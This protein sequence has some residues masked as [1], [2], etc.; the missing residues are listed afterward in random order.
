MEIPF[1]VWL[2]RTSIA[3]AVLAIII[4]LWPAIFF[5]AIVLAIMGTMCAIPLSVVGLFL[6][7]GR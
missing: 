6:T 2:R 7:G 5:K 1:H 3:L 4:W